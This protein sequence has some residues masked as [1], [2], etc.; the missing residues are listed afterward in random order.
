MFEKLNPGKKITMAIILMYTLFFLISASAECPT[1]QPYAFNLGTKCCPNP[2]EGTDGSGV[3][4]DGGMLGYDS[5]CCQG[6][7]V[8]C[9]GDDKCVTRQGKIVYFAIKR[10]M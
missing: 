5:T 8:S 7:P 4:C 10:I 9:P 1:S 6:E 2:T 3:L